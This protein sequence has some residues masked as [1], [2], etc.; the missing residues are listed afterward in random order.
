ME[1]RIMSTGVLGALHQRIRL[2]QVSLR[3]GGPRLAQQQVHVVSRETRL[4]S[5]RRR[6]LRDLRGNRFDGANYSNGGA[7]QD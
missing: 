6:R 5:A 2:I 3:D 4:R 1:K 7:G